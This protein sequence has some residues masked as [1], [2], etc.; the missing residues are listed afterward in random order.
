MSDDLDIRHGGAIAVDTEALR[1]VGHRLAMLATR[2]EDA[3][4]AVRRAHGFI[5]DA[6]GFEG[7]VDLAAL[8]AGGERIGGVCEQ[9]RDA[10]A[11]TL[12][13]ADVYE[14]VELRAEADSL[15]LVG[16]AAA[17]AVQARLDR[18]LASDPRLDGMS[19]WLIADWK[20]RRFEGLDSQFDPGGLMAP[21]LMGGASAAVL[22]GLGTLRPGARLRG[23]A[24]AVSVAA[25]R[26]STPDGP[27]TSL[28]GAFARLPTAPG[29]QVKV[30]RYTLPDGSRQFIAYVKGSQSLAVGG[31]QPWDMRSNLQL[32]TGETSASYQAT[33]DALEAA[34]A[35]PGDRV[36]AVAHSQGGIITAHLA[37]ESGYDVRVQLTAGSPV[38]P[39]LGDDQLLIQLRHT[40]DVV[41][42]LA[43]GGSPAG[44][45]SPDSFTAE[46]VGD[47]SR[48]LQDL[49]LA[50]HQMDAYLETAELVDDS[51]DRRLEALDEQWAEL[52]GAVD[53]TSTEFRAERTG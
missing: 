3:R 25:V 14:V 37:M 51:G 45:G 19:E 2:L 11:G 29:A 16:G 32:Y 26:T 38:E 15:R 23:T 13:M 46:R 48:G 42:S 9:T 24:D 36:D 47:P 43:G 30:E 12:L 40:D 31:S 33:L 6:D 39:A 17:D 20:D 22:S 10:G 8:A 44:T 7:A 28:A 41:S 18:L 50:P 27:P 52:D 53:I 4:A 49:A 1:D 35:E 5:V 34:G 21:F